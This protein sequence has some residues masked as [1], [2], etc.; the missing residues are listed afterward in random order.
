MTAVAIDPGDGRD[1]QQPGSTAPAPPRLAP[2]A[3]SPPY[4][5]VA[6]LGA[7]VTSSTRAYLS[8]FDNLYTQHLGGDH[9]QVRARPASVFAF[10]NT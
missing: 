10:H 1:C 6:E 4:A 2:L 5:A 3:R 7:A 9:E 8:D